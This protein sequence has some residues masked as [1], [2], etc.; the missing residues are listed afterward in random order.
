MIFIA[1][2]YSTIFSFVIV[3]VLQVLMIKTRFGNEFLHT[4]PLKI[5]GW[6]LAILVS[7]V[8]IWV[9]EGRKTFARRR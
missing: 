7:T 3:F 6:V 4:V 8:V 1:S 2:F 5:S 9:E